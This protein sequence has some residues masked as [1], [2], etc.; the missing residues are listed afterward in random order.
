MTTN[1]AREETYTL[2]QAAAVLHVAPRTVRWWAVTQG[3]L[4]Y[5]KMGRRLTFL[6][7]DLGN[8]LR[9]HRTEVR[10]PR[11]ARRGR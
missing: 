5:V 6:E 11:P 2:E 1:V 10:A 3:K 4:A 7:S 9:R 8:F